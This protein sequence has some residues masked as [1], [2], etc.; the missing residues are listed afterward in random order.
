M[1]LETSKP[2]EVRQFLAARN[3]HGNLETTS[4]LEEQPLLGCAVLAWRSQA[5]AMICYGRAGQPELWLFV[6]DSAALPDPPGEQVMAFARVN[7]LNTVAWNRGGKTYLL[8]GAVDDATLRE[9]VPG[10]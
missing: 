10:G 3:A 2:A 6:V 1:E 9:L 4:A 7:R 8:A 5:A